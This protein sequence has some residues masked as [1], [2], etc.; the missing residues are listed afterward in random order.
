MYLDKTLKIINFNVWNH[1]ELMLST[2]IP[3]KIVITEFDVFRGSLSLTTDTEFH[4]LI[5]VMKKYRVNES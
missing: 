5:W 3:I 2:D 4:V 1:V